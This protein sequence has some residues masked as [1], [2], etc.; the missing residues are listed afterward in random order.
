[1]GNKGSKGGKGGKSGDVPAGAKVAYKEMLNTG[2]LNYRAQGITHVPN[3]VFD[4]PNLWKY[5]I[6]THNDFDINSIRIDATRNAITEF[7][8]GFS[9]N[10]LLTVRTVP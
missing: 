5:V 8:S 9:K 2:V 1:M 4:V 3:E 10:K 6:S 7:P